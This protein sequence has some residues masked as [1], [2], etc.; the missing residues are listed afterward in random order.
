[1]IA[2]TPDSYVAA[3]LERSPSALRAPRRLCVGARRMRCWRR[4]LDVGRRG[5]DG[6]AR[7]GVTQ[8]LALAMV[9]MRSRSACDAS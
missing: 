6:R 1:M 8:G 4:C 3:I 2:G 5:P 9:L 7:P